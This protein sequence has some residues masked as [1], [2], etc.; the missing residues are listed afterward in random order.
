MQKSISSSLSVTAVSRRESEAH[1]R[2]RPGT[3]SSTTLKRGF[4]IGAAACGL[5]FLLPLLLTVV[6]LVL[7]AQGRP[8]FIGHKRVGKRG[9]PFACFKF[10]TMTVDAD[11]VLRAHLAADPKASAEWEATRKLKN[12]PRITPLGQV[13]RKSSVD[14]LPQLINVLRGEM[15]LVGPRPIVQEEAHHYGASLSLYHSV[16]PGLTGLWQVGGRSDVSYI[17][18]VQMDADY[19]KNRTFGQDLS[20]LARTVP[21]VMGSKGSY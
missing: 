12:D 13:L 8:I 6:L 3:T 9:V 7:I 18:R 4:D 1:D 11:A 21:A 19:V 15:S 17:R 16:R 5:L 2:D 20:I 10:R 14:E